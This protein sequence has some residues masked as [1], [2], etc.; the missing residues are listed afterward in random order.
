MD[1]ARAPLESYLSPMRNLTNPTYIYLVGAEPFDLGV[2]SAT[3]GV[4]RFSEEHD[5]DL[6]PFLVRHASGDWGDVPVED[7]RANEAALKS[8]ARLFSSYLTEHGAKV[9]IITDAETTACGPCW[10]GHGECPGGGHDEHGTHFLDGRP[11]RL[12]TTI[13]RPSDY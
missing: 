12:T 7:W 13:L 9:W 4:L 3:R 5:I 6:L 10:T 11:R 2:V 1:A 8:G